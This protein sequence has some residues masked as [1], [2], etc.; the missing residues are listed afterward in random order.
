MAPVAA[1]EQ[2]IRAA[3]LDLFL[4][5]GFDQV[6]VEDVAA[7][8]GVS[9]MTF[10]RYFPTKESVVL[11]DP[12]DPMIAA[13][14]RAQDR[15]LAPLERVRQAFLAI[16]AQMDATEDAQARARVRL[17]AGHPRLRAGTW[18]ANQATADAIEVA[19]VAD[20]TTEF[21]AKVVTGAC[22]G[23]I[24]AA[25]LDWGMTSDDEPLADRLARALHH[26][27]PAGVVRSQARPAEAGNSGD[28]PPGAGPSG[29]ESR[30]PDGSA[31]AGS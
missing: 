7:A 20:G 11:T 4:E 25:L 31:G 13:G 30:G 5:H 26:L 21:E 15:S 3:A 1:T 17:V 23:A 18:Q 19:L 6:T 16:T 27:A 8:A 14:V 22:L 10:F 28:V 24:T 29:V 2:R 9:H 12:Y